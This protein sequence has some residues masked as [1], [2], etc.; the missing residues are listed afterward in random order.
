MAHKIS[1][2]FWENQEVIFLGP[3]N[4]LHRAVVFGQ[5]GRKLAGN[6]RLA[7]GRTE[8]DI[9]PHLAPGWGLETPAKLSNSELT[10][11]H[12]KL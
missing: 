11:I 12:P 7:A 1:S 3:Q 8:A 2:D 4:T 9:V 5:V 10:C 6:Q